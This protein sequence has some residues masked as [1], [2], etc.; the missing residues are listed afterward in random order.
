M[1]DVLWVLIC[2]ANRKTGVNLTEGAAEKFWEKEYPDAG[3]H[4]GNENYNKTTAPGEAVVLS[5]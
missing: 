1:A 2:L 4:K 3:R 5:C